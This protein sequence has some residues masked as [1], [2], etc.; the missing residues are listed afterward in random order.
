MHRSTFS[1]LIL[2]LIASG[3]GRRGPDGN[4]RQAV[5]V[6]LSPVSV[7]RLAE[8]VRTSGFLSSQA[9][10]RLGFKTGG[11]I[12][13][14]DAHEGSRVRAGQV[15]ASLQLDEI[16]AL[17]DQAR[18]GFEKASRDFE[19]ANSLFRDSV[20][21]LEQVQDAET[22]LNVAAANLKIAEYNLAH[23]A[24]T[25]PSDGVVLKRLAEPHE[26]IGPGH[27]VFLFGTAGPEWLVKIGLSDRDAV[28]VS[29]GDSASVTFDAFPGV[30]FS[31][32]VRRVAGAPD[33]M[34][35]VFEA[36]VSVRR[37]RHAFMD[38]LM[39][40][41][42]V[43]PAGTR[44]YRL[45]PVEALVEADGGDAAV[46]AVS[47]DS[48]ARRIAVRVGFFTDDSAAIVSGLDTVAAVITEG[49]AYCADG[50]AVRVIGPV[51]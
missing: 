33:P 13:R 3:C 21:T 19:R 18:Q 46:Y 2:L 23:S 30:R 7:R 45:V 50:A 4:P 29:E 25:A 27:P 28:R 14:I 36:A 8:P 6:R 39:A 5:P 34:S 49:A 32:R 42:D 51:R 10:I 38:G 22:G 24:V 15:L 44:E 40:D 12:G 35:G 26:L 11:V 31:G 37:G 47:P 16:R 9:E 41:A 17:A 48:T 1:V 43:F 20:A